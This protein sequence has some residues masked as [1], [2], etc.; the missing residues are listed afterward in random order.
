MDYDNVF[1]AIFAEGE[2][3]ELFY[4]I[5]VDNTPLV[6]IVNSYNL[7]DYFVD[8]LELDDLLLLGAGKCPMIITHFNIVMPSGLDRDAALKFAFSDHRQVALR[9]WLYF[10]QLDQ[11][12]EI[13]KKF[14]DSQE[15]REGA[16][17]GLENNQYLF[18][19]TT[20]KGEILA[21]VFYN[22]TALPLIRGQRMQA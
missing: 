16:C 19:Y 6:S 11:L 1:D 21:Q 20:R 15:G 7:E 13:L 18:E 22:P 8:G 9:T 12:D 5:D 3:S 2:N 17:T 4:T 10:L 14:L